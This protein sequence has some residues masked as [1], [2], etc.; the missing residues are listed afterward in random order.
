MATYNQLRQT[1]GPLQVTAVGRVLRVDA[2]SVAVS[3]PN[4]VIV[5]PANGF[6]FEPGSSVLMVD[7]VPVVEYRSTAKASTFWV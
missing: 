5:H 7:G 2:V 1:I 4:G 6:L 3:S